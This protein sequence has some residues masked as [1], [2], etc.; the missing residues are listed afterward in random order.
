MLAVKIES[1]SLRQYLRAQKKLRS[2]VSI[3]N[4]TRHESD[5]AQTEQQ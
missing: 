1:E 2:I 3:E 5:R 4:I